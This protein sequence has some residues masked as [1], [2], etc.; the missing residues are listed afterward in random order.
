MLS[1]ASLL[2]DLVAVASTTYTEHAYA[3]YLAKLLASPPYNYTVVMQPL[4]DGS[5]RCNV[6]AYRGQLSEIRLLFCSHLD[7][8]PPHIGVSEDADN[9]YGRGSCDAKGPTAAQIVATERLRSMVDEKQIGLLYVVGE[10]RGHDGIIHAN[11][12][13]L[14]PAFLVVGEPTENKLALGHKG[15][16][17]FE[18]HA[19]GK[20]AHSGYPQYGHSAIEDLVE[21]LY[22]LQHATYPTDARL[23]PTTLNLGT[24]KGGAAPNIVPAEAHAELSLRVSTNIQEAWKVVTDTVDALNKSGITLKYQ[25][26]KDPVMCGDVEGFETA[27]EAYFTDIPY[28]EGT[29]QSY[30]LGPGS[31]LVAHAPNEFIS[32]QELEHGVELYVQLALHLLSP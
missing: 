28:F 14:T 7:T 30:L 8:V 22:A 9:I 6:L 13:G 18:V 31:I 4:D 10:E 16:I 19:K 15:M 5:K 24:I 20:A 25:D 29:H 32:K 3:D 27:V 26:G 23:G 12:L 11:K 1:T 17:K 2:K 21:I